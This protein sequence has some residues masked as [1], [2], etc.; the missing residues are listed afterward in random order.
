MYLL[1]IIIYFFKCFK[2]IPR[3]PYSTPLRQ[4]CHMTS[5]YLMINSASVVQLSMKMNLIILHF[6]IQ[7]CLKYLLTVDYIMSQD[8]DV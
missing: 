8:R 3:T 4:H 7:V 6:L 2:K 5:P 1:F